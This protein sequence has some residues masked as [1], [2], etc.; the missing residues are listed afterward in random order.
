MDGEVGEEFTRS[1]S[2]GSVA[3]EDPAPGAVLAS[4][5]ISMR[6]QCGRGVTGGG[7]ST[8]FSIFTYGTTTIV[9]SG[10]AVGKYNAN[11][12]NPLDGHSNN[13]Y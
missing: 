4:V 9:R 1:R 2:T 13:R 3:R 6:T 5:G 8:Q 11:I 12:L 10:Q 7:G